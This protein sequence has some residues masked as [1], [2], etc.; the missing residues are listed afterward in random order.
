MNL[1]K[2][3]IPAITISSM[4][5]LTGSYGRYVRGD[6]TQTVLSGSIDSHRS[7]HRFSGNAKLVKLTTANSLPHN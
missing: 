5:G 7:S 4:E 2:L 6:L 1:S 3:L